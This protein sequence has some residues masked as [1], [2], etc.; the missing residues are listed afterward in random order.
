M[1]NT[2]WQAVL[3]VPCYQMEFAYKDLEKGKKIR[4]KHLFNITSNKLHVAALQVGE[5]H[6]PHLCLG[7]PW[8]W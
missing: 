6:H 4:T 7:K 8:H 2:N 5:K 3:V 1:Q